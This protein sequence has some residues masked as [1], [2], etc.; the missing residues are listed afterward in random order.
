MTINIEISNE[1]AAAIR[2][3]L[4]RHIHDAAV[5]V[6]M[7]KLNAGNPMLPQTVRPGLIEAAQEAIRIEM[8]IWRAINPASTSEIIVDDVW[9]SHILAARTDIEQAE[10]RVREAEYDL[11]KLAADEDRSEA[12]I[13]YETA[14]SA[15]IA[16]EA[17]RCKLV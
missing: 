2:N 4:L 1:L 12:L 13:Q 11:N 16:L 3:D 10:R 7:V 15:L 5:E 14:Q 6:V 17:T 8:S 9:T